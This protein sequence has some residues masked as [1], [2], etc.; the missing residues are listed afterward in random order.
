MND[1]LIIILIVFLA[2][3][4]LAAVVTRL[5][6]VGITL[7]GLAII[8]PILLI[9]NHRYGVKNIPLRNPF[10]V[11]SGRGSNRKFIPLVTIPFRKHSV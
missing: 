10:V 6:R 8:L 5:F 9:H 4:G 7:L 1:K 3:A 11:E 2:I